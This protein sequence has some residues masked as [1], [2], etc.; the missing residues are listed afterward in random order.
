[1][2]DALTLLITLGINEAP[3]IINAIHAAHGTVQ[4]VGPQL[5]ADKVMIDGDIATL[6]AE[7]AAI[8]AAQTTGT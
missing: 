6:K 7:Q 1:M 5:D 3:A 2:P 4:N 8:A